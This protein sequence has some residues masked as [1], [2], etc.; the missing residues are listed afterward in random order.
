MP[1]AMGAT[2]AR[3]NATIAARE[4]RRRF[5]TGPT[6]HCGSAVTSLMRSVLHEQVRGS[7]RH[8]ARPTVARERSHTG[9]GQE[10]VVVRG[11]DADEGV[12]PAALGDGILPSPVNLLVVWLSGRGFESDINIVGALGRSRPHLL[13]NPH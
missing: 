1:K 11:H 3:M 10:D 12:V 8:W 5:A 6:G 2:A 9:A 13:R 7:L 4:N